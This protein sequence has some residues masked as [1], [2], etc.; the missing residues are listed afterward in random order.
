MSKNNRIGITSFPAVLGTVISNQRKAMNIGQSELAN[1]LGVTASTLSRIENGESAMTIDQLYLVS[2]AF[3]M[4]P[5]QLL[6]AAEELEEGLK[7]AGVDAV[8]ERSKL[9]DSNSK[10][11]S[12][13]TVLKGASLLPFALP[14]LGPIGAILAAAIAINKAKLDAKSSKDDE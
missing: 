12:Y 1:K 10:E 2:E 9:D 8:G 14:I 3:S 5:H 13:V 4:K 6:A 11:G 7:K